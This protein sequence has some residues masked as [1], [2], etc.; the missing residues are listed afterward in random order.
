[1][2]TLVENLT[3]RRPVFSGPANNLKMIHS[4]S[5]P[6]FD[7]AIH[8]FFCEGIG[9]TWMPGSRLRQ[10]FDAKASTGFGP[11]PPKL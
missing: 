5:W 4:P 8:V 10:G 3:E 6:G 11:S 1:M 2:L 9:R 7:P